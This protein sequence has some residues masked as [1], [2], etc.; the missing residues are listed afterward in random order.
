MQMQLGF[1]LKDW[2]NVK[3]TIFS[4]LCIFCLVDVAPAQTHEVSIG[5]TPEWLQFATDGRGDP[6]GFMPFR[7]YALVINQ[8]VSG[9]PVLT[10]LRNI[11]TFYCAID[12]EQ[13]S[14]VQVFVPREIDVP[15]FSGGQYHPYRDILFE[16]GDGGLVLGSGEVQENSLFFDVEFRNRDFFAGMASDQSIIV[17]FSDFHRLVMVP[18]NEELPAF[19]YEGF[20]DLAEGSIRGSIGDAEIRRA[21]TEE[22]VE[23]CR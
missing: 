9:Q 13:A 17:Y 7:R 14:Y 15:S 19:G 1:A 11:M 2:N 22:L 23:G 18:V 10:D 3:K 6:P 12:L 21:S 4:V 5:I 8:S 16:F 20:T